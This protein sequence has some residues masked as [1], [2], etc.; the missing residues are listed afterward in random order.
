[1]IAPDT[2]ARGASIR[3]R[4]RRTVVAVTL[5]V[6]APL[7]HAALYAPRGSVSFYVDSLLVAAVWLIG[8]V[9]ASGRRTHQADRRRHHHQRRVIAA[10]CV[11]VLL[12]LAFVGA[13]LVARHLPGLSGALHD[14]LAK[15]DDGRL[16]IVLAVASVSGL[17]E[18][19]FFRGA[20][21]D[22]FSHRYALIG[23]VA[24]YAVV[25]MLT[26]N[27]ALVVAAVVLGTVTAFE[28]RATGGILAPVVTHVVWSMLMILALPR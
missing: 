17:A 12:F 6:A 24:V 5:L 21:Y 8:S 7:L 18:E 20:L 26:G 11:G 25:T 15:A 22:A 2:Q 10:A 14:V 16:V 19:S 1:V 3:M 23:S 28:R 9:I 4:R 27:L 13:D